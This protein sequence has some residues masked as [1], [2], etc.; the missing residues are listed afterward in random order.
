MFE[1]VLFKNRRPERPATLEEYRQGG[2]YQA[3]DDDQ[4]AA[5]G[6]G[7][8]RVWNLPSAER[9][10]WS[11]LAPGATLA[12]TLHDYTL[13]GRTHSGESW[14]GLLTAGETAKTCIG[15]LKG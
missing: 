5:R 8:H 4:Q 14:A 9:L 2:G 6:G 1:E 11:D 15:A 13:I 3:K 12:N 10:S 7:A